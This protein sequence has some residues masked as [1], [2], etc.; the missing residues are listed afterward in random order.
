MNASDFQSYVGRTE[1]RQDG[2]SE[3]TLA[4]FAA[5]LAIDAP[6]EVPQG[7]H[8][9]LCQPDATTDQL[10]DDG[11]PA[12]REFLPSGFLP[13]RMWA[14]SD[15]E[16]VAPLTIG[17][18]IE[19]RS[20]IDSITPKEGKSGALLF[21]DVVHEWHVDRALAIRERQ[22]I[23]YREPAT[24]VQALPA[25]VAL[26]LSGWTLSRSLTPT[27]P[28]LFRYSAITFDSHRI[29]YDLPYTREEEFYPGLVVH[30]PLM[31]TLLLDL[32]RRA[33]G[34]D[35]LAHF[36]FQA[37]SPAFVDQPMH[38]L[39]RERDGALELRAMGVDGRTVLSAT[40]R[41]RNNS[42]ED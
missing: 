4:R 24:S 9:C 19:R 2:I 7:L 39:G 13:R 26:D 18:A 32:C 3:A 30:G 22:T 20:A 11:H 10:G 6:Q 29:H 34:P 36:A 21:I 38:L 12:G 35:A 31:A 1:M 25:S 42:S 40:G 8:W 5:T 28:L 37:V 14:A 16:F 15:V 27:P 23:V 17:A 33:F 41:L